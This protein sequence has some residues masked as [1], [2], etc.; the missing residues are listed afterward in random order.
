MN[1]IIPYRQE[2][3]EYARI[4]RNNSTF[5]EILLWQQIKAKKMGV[6]FKR[7]VPMLDFIVDFYCP[8]ILLAIEVDGGYHEHQY[9]E[10]CRRQQQIEAYGIHFLRFTNEEVKTDMMNVLLK[11]EN[12][13]NELR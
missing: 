10:D 4:L 13:I 11:I 5:P 8:E 9:I 6:G 12:K 7:Q 2:L 3:R 1:K